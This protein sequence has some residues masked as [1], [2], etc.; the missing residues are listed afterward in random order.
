MDHGRAI[1][2]ETREGRWEHG[3]QRFVRI[4]GRCLAGMRAKR[5]RDGHSRLTIRVRRARVSVLARMFPEFDQAQV[6]SGGDCSNTS[7]VFIG[8]GHWSRAKHGVLPA[9]SARVS[10]CDRVALV[11]RPRIDVRGWAR[12]RQV[13]TGWPVLGLPRFDGQG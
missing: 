11:A 13:A 8:A 1:H 2:Q 12:D 5:E 7:S 9:G 6:I 3:L 10:S 4:L